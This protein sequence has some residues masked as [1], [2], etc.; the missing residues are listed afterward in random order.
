MKHIHSSRGFTLIELLV[1]ISIIAV[2][3]SIAVPAFTGV[4]ER[5]AQTKALSNAKQ[6][7]LVCKTFAQDNNGNYP[8]YTLDSN[9]KPTTT[10]VNDA[11]TAFAQLI[12]DYLTDENLFVVSKSKWTPSGADGQYDNPQTASPTNTLKQGENH[13][14]LVTGLSDTSNSSFPLIADGFVSGGQT[15]HKYTVDQSQPG[16]VWKGKKSIVIRCDASGNILKV[17]PVSL[18]VKGPVGAS[19]EQD[20]FTTS[21]STD[22]WLGS[23]NVVVNPK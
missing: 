21:N 2:L 7:G 10:T 11:N 14:A 8:S 3:A 9:L 13:W 22:G 1:V 12:P 20:I 23:G 4:Q 15:S 19:Q 17:D 18:T 5:A 6:I 16:G